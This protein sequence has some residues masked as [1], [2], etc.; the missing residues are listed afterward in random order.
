MDTIKHGRMTINESNGT[1]AWRHPLSSNHTVEVIAHYYPD[2]CSLVVEHREFGDRKY[3]QHRGAE[4][5]MKDI[6]QAIED[7]RSGKREC[8]FTGGRHEA[9]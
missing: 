1:V 7:A 4:P 9:T 6:K 5:Y 2:S 3:H 8:Q